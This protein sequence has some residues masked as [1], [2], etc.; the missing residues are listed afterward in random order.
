MI[1]IRSLTADDALDDL[2]SLSREFFEEYASHHEDFFSI[3]VLRD[4]QIVNYFSRLL[5]GVAADVI[6]AVADGRIVGYVTVYVREQ[7]DYW[8]VKRVGDI[9]GL[10]VQPAYRGQGIGRLLMDRAREFFERQG[11]RY[12]TVYTAVENRGAIEFYERCGLRPLYTTLLGEV[13]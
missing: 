4:E 10:M 13:P 7:P 8:N 1:E 2:I 6:I 9:S 3:D 12:F 5:A 11:V